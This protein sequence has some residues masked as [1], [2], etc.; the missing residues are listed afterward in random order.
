M[1]SSAKSTKERPAYAI[2]SVDHALRLAALLQLE[3]ATTV[4]DAAARLG[5]A[6]STAHRLLASAPS[7][8][9]SGRHRVRWG[10]CATPR[11]ARWAA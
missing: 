4:T 5:V 1:G 8:R 10:G 3:G 11:S 9:A 7:W 2:T 6:P